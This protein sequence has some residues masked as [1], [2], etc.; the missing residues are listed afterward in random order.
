[1]QT[2][3]NVHTD[4][5]LVSGTMRL[6]AHNAQSYDV[7][8]ELSS[9]ANPAAGVDAQ[10]AAGVFDLKDPYYRQLR[11]TWAPTE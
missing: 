6:K 4:G 1:M 10:A 11:T 2:P 3:I 8:L 9:P 5:Q 7:H